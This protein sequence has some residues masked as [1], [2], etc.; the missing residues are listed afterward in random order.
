MPAVDRDVARALLACA[1]LAH[2]EVE[3]AGLL[4]DDTAEPVLAAVARWLRG[5]ATDDEVNAVRNVMCDVALDVPA[6]SVMGHLYR[7]VD[8]VAC[9]VALGNTSGSGL[10]R[11][12]IG[13]QAALDC[14]AALGEPWDAAEARVTA[15]WEGAGG[16]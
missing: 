2:D 5:E 14:L 10:P 16:S 7:C 9:V 8:A 11:N 3:R 15:A 6:V 12:A 1:R 4:T 13:M